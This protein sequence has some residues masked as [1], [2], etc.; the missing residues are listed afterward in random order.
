M[1]NF[2][3]KAAAFA[4][5]AGALA[6]PVMAQDAAGTNTA[7]GDKGLKFSTDGF[8]LG[9]KSGVKASLTYQNEVGNGENGTNGRDFINFRIRR[10]ET[11]FAGHIFDKD[12]QYT[13]RLVWTNSSQEILDIAKFRWAWNQY[14]NVN[15]GQDKLRWSWEQSAGNWSIDFVDRG[16]VDAVFNQ[17][18]AKGLWIDGQVGEDT[19][20]VKYWFGFYNGVLRANNDFRNHDIRVNA[21]SFSDGVVDGDMMINLRVE[22]HPMGAVADKMYDDRAEDA[23]SDVRFAVGLGFNWFISG[24]DNSGIRPDTGAGTPASLRNR[25]SQ[26]TMAVTLDG[27]FR[28]HGL[29]ADLAW[30]WRHSDLHNKGRNNFRPGQGKAGI[31]DLEDSGIT[32]NVGYFILPQDLYVGFRY[33]MLNADD[34]WQGSNDHQFGI[35]PDTTEMGIT[36]AYFVHGENLK[37]TMDIF[38]VDQQLSF[39]NSSGQLGVYNSIPERNAFGGG[40][41][42]ADHN[43]L[44]IVRFALQWL[45]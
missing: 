20:W 7:L 14:L 27:H 6:A 37:L 41:E 21:E 1:G 3:S 18:Y 8:E 29:S 38:Y 40:L 45:F 30:Y 32:F 28:W 13:V 44:W 9:I 33:N 36:V 35:R 34:F 24:F 43:S 25:T 16:Y 39:D 15:V 5:S 17:S 4:L 19:P 10:A 26:D 11:T 22:T 31:A 12:L 42:N 2:W 23:Y